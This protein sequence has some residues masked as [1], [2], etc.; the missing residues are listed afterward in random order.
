MDS[1]LQSRY[2]PAVRAARELLHSAPATHTQLDPDIDSALLLR[3]LIQFSAWAVQMTE[4][5]EGWI[6]RAGERCQELGLPEIGRDLVLHATHEAGHHLMLV[7]DTH[8][9]VK[10]WNSRFAMQ[11][12]A[13]E[14]L[15]Q[16]ATPAMRR[17]AALHE[18]T[19]ESDAPY[20]QVAIELEIEG[21]ST[22]LGNGFIQNCRSVLGS[23]ALEGLSFIREHV[24][25]DVGHTAFNTRL[26]ERLLRLRPDAAE[27]LAAIGSE[28][29]RTYVEFFAECLGVATYDWSRSQAA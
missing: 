25:I 11:L 27:E 7:R 20:G 3:F 26:M 19:I 16:R 8:I 5:V 28:A 10:R 12:D 4:P 17:Y 2:I 1:V 22:T 18:R 21:M 6:R 23:E 15:R 13:A 29:L 24:A 9:L 14:L